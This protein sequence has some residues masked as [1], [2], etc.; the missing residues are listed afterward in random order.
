VRLAVLRLGW[1]VSRG[2]LC[3]TLSVE[4]AYVVR[5]AFDQSFLA[6]ATDEERAVFEQH[7]EWLEARYAEGR[8]RFAGRCYDGPFGLVVLDA[9]SEEDARRL[10][11]EDP[12]VRAGVQSAEL[13]PFKTFLARER[14][15]AG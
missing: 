15:P 11:E 1:T 8:V 5:P 4:F 3:F 13:H 12:S 9:A 10:M 7:G 6:L 14:G 2:P